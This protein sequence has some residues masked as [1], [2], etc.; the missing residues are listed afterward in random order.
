MH[1]NIAT[2]DGGSSHFRQNARCQRPLSLRR[3][4]ALA[5]AA[6]TFA[7]GSPAG[8][9]P[10]PTSI[11]SFAE[12]FEPFAG[13]VAPSYGGTW[14]GTYIWN[15]CRA[16]IS[17]LCGHI[18]PQHLPLRFDLTQSGANLLGTFDAFD[19]RFGFAG[20]VT[21][22]LGIAGVAPEFLNGSEGNVTVRFRRA[23]DSFVGYLVRDSWRDTQLLRSERFFIVNPLTRA[24]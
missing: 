11:E 7:C 3:T 22:E 6:M 18:F 2:G 8:P 20:T 23:G 9:S 12:P 1:A 17:L 13:S 19:R 15:E 14:T 24:E 5:C 10:N 21:K 16:T 4:I